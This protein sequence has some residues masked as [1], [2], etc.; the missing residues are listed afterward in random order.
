MLFSKNPRKTEIDEITDP[1]RYRTPGPGQ[2]PQPK[3][4]IA[5]VATFQL[6]AERSGFIE[7]AMSRANLSPGPYKPNFS[8]V[9]KRVMFPRYRSVAK[10]SSTIK[11]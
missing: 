6:K 9:E 1:K 3:R 10:N 8:I 4:R 5:S 11:I 7:E 2:Y